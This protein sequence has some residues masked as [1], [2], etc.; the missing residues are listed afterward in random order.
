[1][2]Y[3]TQNVARQYLRWVRVMEGG[4]NGNADYN[5]LNSSA[6]STR[7]P[8]PPIRT[9]CQSPKMMENLLPLISS[10]R[11]QHG[12]ITSSRKMFARAVWKDIADGI[13]V[14]K[15]KTNKTF[16]KHRNVMNFFITR[17]TPHS[18][19]ARSHPIHFQPSEFIVVSP[20]SVKFQREIYRK[21]ISLA[22][23]RAN[24][25]E[26]HRSAFLTSFEFR[27]CQNARRRDERLIN[28]A[29]L[30]RRI[31]CAIFQLATFS[32]LHSKKQK[33]P[34]TTVQWISFS[35]GVLTFHRRLSFPPAK[36]HHQQQQKSDW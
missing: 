10:L 26:A 28:S 20:T 22:C 23:G 11:V 25:I 21:T 33:D 7:D 12:L 3:H 17:D 1:M 34:G 6:K 13:S 8:S 32:L 35:C 9:P 29:P 2:I 18:P 31:N 16:P 19:R 4:G 5:V 14:E 30:I 36:K 27:S 15:E 24:A